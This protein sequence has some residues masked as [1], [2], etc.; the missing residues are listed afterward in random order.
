M[1][2]NRKRVPLPQVSRGKRR[3]PLCS[4]E[5]LYLLVS[6]LL[7]IRRLKRP[8]EERAVLYLILDNKKLRASF[9]LMRQ[10]RKLH[11]KKRQT[12]PSNFTR[13]KRAPFTPQSARRDLLS[14]QVREKDR[15]YP[16][17]LF[18]R[19]KRAFAKKKGGAPPKH[20]TKKS[21]PVPQPVELKNKSSTSCSN[22]TRDVPP[23]YFW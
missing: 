19:W 5:L 3:E 15:D 14:L 7:V 18:K 2:H 21:G 12:G 16:L 4:R 17:Y 6:R 8:R 13:N 1:V 20:Q 10:T 11:L 23:T 9:N 22:T